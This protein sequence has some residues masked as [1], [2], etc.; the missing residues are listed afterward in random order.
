MSRK[1]IVL[2]L[3][4]LITS[5]SSDPETPEE[6]VEITLPSVNTSVAADVSENSAIVGGN[7]TNN[8][9]A[10]VSDRGV[11]W[12]TI[13][14]PTT[15]DNKISIGNGT[16]AFSTTLTGLEEN[17]QY[18]VRAFAVNTQGTA[19]G[20]EISFTTSETTVNIYEGDV[21]L[22]T[23][24]EVDDF[25]IMGYQQITG[26]LTLGDRTSGTPSDITDLSALI[27]LTTIGS[28]LDIWNNDN[29]EVFNGLDTIETVAGDI[30]IN[31]N[32]LLTSLSALGGVGSISGELI[33]RGNDSLTDIDGFSS[34]ISQASRVIVERN[35]LLQS[36][37]GFSGLSEINGDLQIRENGS[38]LHLDELA[39]LR[40]VRGNLVV[41]NNLNL[42]DISG[43]YDLE[44]IAGIFQLTTGAI[45]EIIGFNN[46]T[47]ISGGLTISSLDNV[48]IISGFSNLIEV[49]GI[50][51]DNN[52]ILSACSG[53]ESL[54]NLNGDLVLLANASLSSISAFTKI[55]SIQGNFT[56]ALNKSFNL[57]FLT[58]L[59][60]VQGSLRIG[61][62]NSLISTNGLN[63][64]AFVGGD[65]SLENLIGQDF[66]DFDLLES[67]GGDLRI[68]FNPNLQTIEFP[69]LITVQGSVEI[70]GNLSDFFT[71][72]TPWGLQNIGGSLL[73]RQNN[74][75]GGF[76]GLTNLAS[77]QN[78]TDINGDIEI[79]DNPR[80]R[81]FCDLQT[82]LGTFT[83]GYLVS[84]NAY[85]PTQQNIVDGNCNN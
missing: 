79:V 80:L 67:I 60:E 62:D 84:G 35:D 5:C 73:I 53:F 33:I 14:N 38:L 1:F 13:A 50:S 63:N 51:I 49:G 11:V 45:A 65:V 61:S 77:F 9:G 72:E 4:M 16:G 36:L 31:G 8:G 74:P 83:G 76:V 15:D 18:F 64:L 7:V 48:T 21:V 32:D 57:S 70:Q 54:Q 46:L 59:V 29:L 10:P 69:S 55:E 43:I 17:T 81:D 40:T 26:S 24:Q 71:L 6:V 27:D 37:S 39:S 34:I 28:K 78:L 30:E 42:N 52:N 19:Y 22:K 68:R 23:Q 44:L 3:I 41:S 56:Y 2:T 66:D 12:G 75:S 58:R 85:N 47:E 20:D 25:G 82:A